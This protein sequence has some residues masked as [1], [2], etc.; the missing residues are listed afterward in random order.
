MPMYRSPP[1]AL[2]NADSALVRFLGATSIAFTSANCVSSIN[3]SFSPS[4]SVMTYQDGPIHRRWYNFGNDVRYQRRI[5]CLVAWTGS[6]MSLGSIREI[7][8][9]TTQVGAAELPVSRPAKI[10]EFTALYISVRKGVV[11]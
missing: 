11:F 10:D 7:T 1:S 9:L 8:G 2:A 3:R 4:L 6:T 5:T